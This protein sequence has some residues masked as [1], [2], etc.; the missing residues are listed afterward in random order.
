MSEKSNTNLKLTAIRGA[1]TSK[2]DTE[3][4]IKEAVI[5][6][7]EQLICLNDL[8]QEHIISITFTV[9]KD[10]TSCFPAAIARKFFNFDSV[11]FLDCQQMFVPGDIKFC[12]RVMA[13]VTLKHDRQPVHTY[14]NESSKLRPDRC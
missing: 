7:I 13:L 14:L 5:E 8:K 10:L 4:Y 12:I 6:L 11:A 2:G 9:T 3:S 1:T